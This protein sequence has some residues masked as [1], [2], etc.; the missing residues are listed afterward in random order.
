MRH[1]FLFIRAVCALLLAAFLFSVNATPAQATT[2]Y[3]EDMVCGAC[4]QVSSQRIFSSFYFPFPPDMD[5]QPAHLAL[6]G[7]DLKEC[8]HCGYIATNFSKP[9]SE[10][11]RAV[12]TSPAY[13]GIATLA[14]PDPARPYLRAA[15]L[16]E[17]EGDYVAAGLNMSDAAW[18]CAVS[19]ARWEA[20]MERW[21]TANRENGKGL[22]RT[23]FEFDLDDLPKYIE[24]PP[25]PPET[26]PELAALATTY[27]GKALVLL[28]KGMDL[29]PLDSET[30]F[31]VPYLLLELNRRAGNFERAKYFLAQTRTL[32][33]AKNDD[34]DERYTLLLDR[35]EELINN[36]ISSRQ[37]AIPIFNKLN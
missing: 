16:E 6:R 34:N 20:E 29:N 1:V 7:S 30:H 37:S 3:N 21:E 11:A 14:V 10:A 8:P 35:E 18:L 9:P 23:W 27:R 32:S 5:L 17:A 4:G 33:A 22:E 24:F 19:E 36:K 12:F 2:F 13:A 15:L 26:T 28:E 25:L 31:F